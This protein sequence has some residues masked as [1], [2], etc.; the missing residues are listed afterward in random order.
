M[1]GRVIEVRSLDHV[2]LCVKDVA[3]TRAFYERVLGMQSRE[4]RSGKW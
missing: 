1:E 4:E 2:V 3:A